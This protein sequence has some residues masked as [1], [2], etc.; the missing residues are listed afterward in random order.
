MKILD[1]NW[2][3]FLNRGAFWQVPQGARR[4]FVDKVVP[5]QAL[6]NALMGEWR[7]LLPFRLDGI[8]RK[9]CQC[10]R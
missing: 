5:S 9:A 7:E 8:R 4:V 1:V 3:D 6:P 2:Q 10:S